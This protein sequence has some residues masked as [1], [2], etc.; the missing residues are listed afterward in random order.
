M[1]AEV[2]S[3]GD[4]LTS[5]AR[6]DTNSQWISQR[7]VELGVAVRFHTTVA[8]DLQTNVDVFRTAFDRA[9]VVIANGGLGPTAD[10]LTREAV[11]RAAA[12]Q[13]VRDDQALA[14]IRAKF[15]RRGQ[16][17]PQ[18]NEVQALRPAGG[19]VVPNPHGTA[20]GIDLEIPRAGRGP[21]RLFALPGVPSELKAMWH[22]SVGA[23]I[24]DLRPTAL[25]IRQHRIQCFGAGESQ[26]EAMLPGLIE[27]G[28]PPVVGITAS[29][30]TITLRIS[31][32]GADHRQ[33]AQ[34]LQPTIDTIHRCLG[35]LVFGEGDDELQHA[36]AR[37]LVRA[38]AS[39]ATAEWGTGG[40]I[41]HWLTE[42]TVA[43]PDCYRGGWVVG[44]ATALP[45]ALVPGTLPTTLRGDDI[46]PVMEALAVNCRDQMGAD[47]G[48]ATGPLPPCPATEG[49]ASSFYVALATATGVQLLAQGG[50]NDPTTTRVRCA[51]QALN[52]VRLTLLDRR[53]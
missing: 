25:V 12:T 28:R 30:S 23:A 14:D 50:G 2:I 47:Y 38:G 9:D 13:L 49:A 53:A 10:D 5:G 27:R 7:L 52:V 34:A 1:N 15:E 4:E 46:R 51:K 16:P 31:T 3:I 35:N 11:A 20:P 41:A 18:R 29:Q 44:S 24:A 45:T 17:M 19:R 48:L 32:A 21:C 6:L 26:I 37:L 43:S 22:A 40:L 33:C 39:L 36:V 42:S 8:D